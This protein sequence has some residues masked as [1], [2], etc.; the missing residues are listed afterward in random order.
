M[1]AEKEHAGKGAGI[2]FPL[3]DSLVGMEFFPDTETASLPSLSK[4]I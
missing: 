4:G 1:E 3:P 2:I